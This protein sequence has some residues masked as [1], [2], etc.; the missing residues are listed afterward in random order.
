MPYGDRWRNRRRLLHQNLNNT[1]VKTHLT[2]QNICIN[3]LLIKL[4]NEPRRFL[5][6]IRL[7]G[8]VQSYLFLSI[9]YWS[10][11]AT[12]LAMSIAYAHD[13]MDIHDPFVEA[14]EEAIRMISL[15]TFPGAA[16]VNTIPMCKFIFLL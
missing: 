15:T 4:L 13:V 6:H 10:S 14:S 3:R 9:H 5:D 12:G 16:M 2:A 11:F 8:Y 1:V 7:Y